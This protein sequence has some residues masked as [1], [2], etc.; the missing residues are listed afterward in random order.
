MYRV[1]LWVSFESARNTD[2]T[3][4]HADTTT[5]TERE[6]EKARGSEENEVVSEGAKIMQTS[7]LKREDMRK[8]R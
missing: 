7:T 8:A 1:Q 3:E 4:T 5:Q 6:R 2:N